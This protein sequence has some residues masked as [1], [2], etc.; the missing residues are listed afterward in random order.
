MSWF[1]EMEA[2]GEELEAGVRV[3]RR[4]FLFGGVGLLALPG[5]RR[6]DDEPSGP[7]AD[8]DAFLARAA[9]LARPMMDA[10]TPREDGDLY[11][12]AS[13][14]ADLAQLPADPFEGDTR[15]IRFHGDGQAVIDR[16]AGQ[17]LRAI[18]I[19]FEPGAKISL[20]DHLN[21]SGV[22]LCV[23]GE[24]HCRN[25]DIVEEVGE[26]EVTLFESTNAMLVPGRMCTLS[27]TRENLHELVAGPSG[28]RVLDVFTYL[29]KPSGSRYLDW[30]GEA[31]VDEA[32]R[33][34][35]AKWNK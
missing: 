3:E 2:V 21:Y 29:R 19:G 20:H 23:Q 12:L 9:E 16:D 7:P 15:P 10:D 25:F 28:A 26:D 32:A 24:M 8:V 4:G 30:I 34:Y 22:I 14:M 17:S 18:Q 1:P 27:S 31:P 11:R 35:R 5:L 13:W 33:L 6:G